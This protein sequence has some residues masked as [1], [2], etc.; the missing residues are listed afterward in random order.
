[1]VQ[2]LH[3]GLDQGQDH[4]ACRH[5]VPCSSYTTS[6]VGPSSAS[7]PH[8]DELLRTQR[9]SSCATLG[10]AAPSQEG[11]PRLPWP[12]RAFFALLPRFVL[13]GRSGAF[14]PNCARQALSVG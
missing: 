6:R 8:L 9:A 11:R 14:I 1:M 12:E 4:K 3:S 10:R 7:C 5:S 13:G 2:K